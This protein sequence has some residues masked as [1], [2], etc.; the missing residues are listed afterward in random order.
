MPP[1]N[2]DEATSMTKPVG[3]SAT[4]LCGSGMNLLDGRCRD[5]WPCTMA[6]A[7]VVSGWYC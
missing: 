7:M 4:G 1:S 3:S 6:I 2:N 5:S